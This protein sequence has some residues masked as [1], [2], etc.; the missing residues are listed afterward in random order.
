LKAL[1]LPDF[2]FNIR[3]EEN[4]KEIFDPVR[5][6]YVKLTPEEWVRQHF[7]KYLI[8][9]GKY[10]AGLIG[11]EV[12]FKYSKLSRR[13]DILVHKRT[14]EPVM[15]IEC[16]SPD[17]TINDIVFDQIVCYNMSF[18]VPYLIVTNG[19]D[20]FACKI[21]VVNSTY[22]FLNVIPLYED[23]LS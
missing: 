18:K 11:I 8:Q 4:K 5:K 10:P 17:V 23:L 21:D 19:I 3:G 22:E 7:V 6:K 1:N 15:I 14:G 16:K 9:N 13:V 20:H 2:S 12:M